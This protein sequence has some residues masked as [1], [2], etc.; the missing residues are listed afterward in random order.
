[1]M[2]L[3]NAFS[4]EELQA[5]ADRLAKQVPEDTAFVCEL[6][7]DG[8]AISLTLPRRPVRPGGH[9]GRRHDRRGRHRQRGHHRRHPRIASTRRSGPLP[10]VIEVRGEV[11]MPISAFDELNRRQAEAGERLFVNPRNSAA[12]SLRQKDPVDHRQPG[13]VVLGLPGRASCSRRPSPGGSATPSPALAATQSATLAWLATGRVPGQSRASSWSTGST[14]CSPSAAGGRST[15]TTSTT[16]STASWSRSTTW[17]SSGSS[18]R[19]H[20]P[21]GGPSPTSSRPRSGPPR[22]ST[23][24][25]LDRPDRQGHPVRRAGAGLRRRLHRRRWPPCTTRTRSGSR[26]SVPATR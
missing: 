21:P 14:R 22:C 17:R 13:A 6:K 15:A 10:D 2:S 26:T 20:G 12:G 23:S 24:R 19:R 3:D 7:I 9:P 1:M 16:R 18:V 4:P 5:W 25:C 11:Y 8:L